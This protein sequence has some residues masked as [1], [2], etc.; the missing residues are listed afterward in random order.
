MFE[1]GPI[2]TNRDTFH[3]ESPC[4]CNRFQS[5]ANACK[6]GPSRVARP[7]DFAAWQPTPIFQQLA[8]WSDIPASEM[9][10]VLNM[11]IGFCL[12]TAPGDADG[13][14]ELCGHD[15]LVIGKIAPANG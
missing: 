1:P 6:L 11:G 8:E 7:I 12:I 10:G 5:W 2:R 15:A 4:Y 14:I 9:R 13:L 3:H